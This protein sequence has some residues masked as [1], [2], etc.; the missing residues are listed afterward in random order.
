MRKQKAKLKQTSTAEGIAYLKVH[1]PCPYCEKGIGLLGTPKDGHLPT[2]NCEQCEE[3]FIDDRCSQIAFMVGRERALREEA[4]ANLRKA[5]DAS[6][7]T[8]APAPPQPVEIELGNLE[9]I[10]VQIAADVRDIKTR[11]RFDDNRYEGYEHYRRRN[12]ISYPRAVA[13]G[14]GEHLPP[15]EPSPQSQD[16]GVYY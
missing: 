3:L 2:F 12:T 10:L 16:P 14:K 5:Q 13:P 1:Y 15:P 4:E 9:D 8:K 11:L 6:N 7:A